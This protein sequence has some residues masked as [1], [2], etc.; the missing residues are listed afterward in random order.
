M[1]NRVE[2]QVL[3]VNIKSFML[4]VGVTIKEADRLLYY[5]RCGQ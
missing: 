3:M 4:R 1:A 2:L 5:N